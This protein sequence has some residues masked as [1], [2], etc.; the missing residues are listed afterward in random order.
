MYPRGILL[1]MEDLISRLDVMLKMAGPQPRVMLDT[2]RLIQSG[3]LSGFEPDDVVRAVAAADVMLLVGNHTGLF[4]VQ[5]QPPSAGTLNDPGPATP[6]LPAPPNG[7]PPAIAAPQG[8]AAPA[9][10]ANGKK[11][12]AIGAP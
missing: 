5:L 1:P 4:S 10:T 8:K 9:I 6:A 12:A 2:R 7:K 11:P 3:I